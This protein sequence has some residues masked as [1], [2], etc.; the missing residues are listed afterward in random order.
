M[1][2]EWV[3]DLNPE[4]YLVVPT[5]LPDLELVMLPKPNWFSFLF[6]EASASNWLTGYVGAKQVSGS[7]TSEVTCPGSPPLCT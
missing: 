7:K 4:V 1:P 3:V 2:V 5:E 6:L